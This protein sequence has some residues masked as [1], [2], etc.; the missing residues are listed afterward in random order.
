MALWAQKAPILGLVVLLGMALA[1]VK[2]AGQGQGSATVLEE[3]G[4]HEYPVSS[5]AL[6][7]YLEHTGRGSVAQGRS[8][9]AM[10]H[11][12]ARRHEGM[13]PGPW[14]SGDHGRHRIYKMDQWAHRHG[15]WA[16][17]EAKGEP[18]AELSL[19]KHDDYPH[20]QARTLQDRGG[21]SKRGVHD[22]R[23]AQ[24]LAK[25]AQL[26]AEVRAGQ[27]AWARLDQ[28]QQVGGQQEL[29]SGMEHQET[30][31]P[32]YFETP[33]GQVVEVRSSAG[34]SNVASPSTAGLSQQYFLTPSG[35]VVS[36]ASLQQEEP[37][38]VP[39]SESQSLSQDTDEL[40]GSSAVVHAAPLL[41]PT[42]R[43][44]NSYSI[45]GTAFGTKG[46]LPARY[47]PVDKGSRDDI[48]G[49]A[50]AANGVPMGSPNMYM[51]SRQQTLRQ[52]QGQS[53]YS[54][55]SDDPFEGTY[56]FKGHVRPVPCD[57]PIKGTDTPLCVARKAMSQALQAEKDVI[58]AH[59]KEGEQKNRLSRLNTMYAERYAA[60]KARFE[61]TVKA[62]R[63]QLATQKRRV[64]SDSRRITTGDNLSLQKIA[65]AR[66][67]ELNDWASLNRRL[68]QLEVT[69][70]LVKK[71]PG[72]Q[73]PSGE[74]GPMGPTGVAGPQG[75]PGERGPTGPKGPRGEMGEKGL[76]GLNGVRGPA[77]NPI[78]MQGYVNP[79]G[80]IP[81][82][83]PRLLSK[84]SNNVKQM[85][86]MLR[87]LETRSS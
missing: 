17:S 25:R 27:H 9:L 58:A 44:E 23:R 45:A 69:L 86:G 13:A 30:V 4:L 55:E 2:M 73:G 11:G 8:S 6:R 39:A 37:N 12:L 84:F 78:E 60:L 22:S 29:A 49:G 82:A 50:V 62:L 18:R 1:A 68:N 52:Q 57:G 70:A 15:H 63:E 10:L 31:A 14:K 87:K 54:E 71:E 75:P 24:L 76:N 36:T 28:E 41:D 32:Q 35:Q 72:P 16:E 65:Q 42:V 20:Q 66:K 5:G 53:L 79:Q 46:T 56:K 51:K 74:Q 83:Q 3:T 61:S 47:Y 26:L 19:S 59:E 40:D 85:D 38:I 21:A 43:P 77:G 34:V 7:G 81:L 80:A 33:Q 67:T 64:L 48:L